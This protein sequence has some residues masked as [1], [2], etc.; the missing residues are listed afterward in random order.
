MRKNGLLLAAALAAFAAPAQAIPV[1]YTF[2]PN[3]TYVGWT[4]SHFGF[5]NASGKFVD[6]GGTLMLDEQLPQNSSVEATIRI[7]SLVT[8]LPKFDE[9]LKSD[10]F[11]KAAKFP[12][13]A[14]KS[15]KVELTGKDA[16]K[17]T[18][19]FTML[20]ITREVVLDVKLNKIGNSIMGNKKM[21]G[22]SATATIQ[23]SVFGMQYGIPGVGDAIPI[24]IEAEAQLA[25]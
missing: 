17:V 21:A 2:E 16:A 6:V 8:G 22:F 15:K 5:S 13:A 7:N 12:E 18:G 19:D 24:T 4:A 3:H 1:K 20:G 14:F 10:D 23:R 9:H 11:F 25:E